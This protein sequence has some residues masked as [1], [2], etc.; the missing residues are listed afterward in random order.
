MFS[1][2]GGIQGSSHMSSFLRDF[3][4][5]WSQQLPCFTA[6]PQSAG[7]RSLTFHQLLLFF[8]FSGERWDVVLQKGQKGHCV[9]KQTG[10]TGESGDREADAEGGKT[11][12]LKQYVWFKRCQEEG[13]C[14]GCLHFLRAEGERDRNRG[15]RDKLW[16]GGGRS[17]Q[18]VK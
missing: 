3:Y 17:D 10:K 1:A 7:F 8:C 4:T 5:I 13:V 6:H 11:E 12:S 9:C 15:R 2:C 16:N 14:V 18:Y